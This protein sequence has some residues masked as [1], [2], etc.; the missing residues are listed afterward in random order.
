MGKQDIHL[1][2]ESLLKE[3]NEGKKESSATAVL[4][5]NRNSQGLFRSLIRLTLT[6]WGKKIIL[7]ALALIIVIA[8]GVWYFTR[9]DQTKV[10]TT[11][12]EQVH[13]LATLATAEAHVKVVIEEEDNRI[14]GKDISMDLPGTKRELLLVVPATVIAGVDLKGIGANQIQFDEKDKILEITLPHATLVQEP[15]IDMD[16]VIMFSDEG[17]FR[18]EVDWSEGFDLASR[19]QSDIKAEA[20]DIGLLQ[21]AEKSADKVLT[22]F[23]ANLGYTVK[24][25]FE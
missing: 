21:T 10:T 5:G 11:F 25:T 14:F 17:L 15:A 23:F 9:S 6:I 12:V 18:S 20:E 19:A 4:R 24:V 13:E 8:S 1:Q 2:I 16:K 7:I 3:L 22:E